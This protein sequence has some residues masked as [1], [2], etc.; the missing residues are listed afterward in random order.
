LVLRLTADP[1]FIRQYNHQRGQ[2]RGCRSNA[3]LAKCDALDG[4]SDGPAQDTKAC[5]A[6]QRAAEPRAAASPRTRPPG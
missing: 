5:Q 6:A 2:R 4:A 1:G 3:V